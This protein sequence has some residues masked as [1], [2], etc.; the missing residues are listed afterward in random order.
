[1]A[2]AK[3][4]FWNRSSSVTKNAATGA[5]DGQAPR[6]RAKVRSVESLAERYNLRPPD[7]IVGA[8]SSRYFLD[9]GP[10]IVLADSSQPSERAEREADMWQNIL[11]RHQPDESKHT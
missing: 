4:R 8:E 5:G 11:E 2:R 7:E 3:R 1:M 6:W 9:Y 10:P